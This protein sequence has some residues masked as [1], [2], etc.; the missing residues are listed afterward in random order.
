MLA[1]IS[2][3]TW[4]P[5]AHEEIVRFSLDLPKPESKSNDYA[6]PFLGWMVGAKA[7]V[8]RVEVNTQRGPHV[9]LAAGLARDDVGISFPDVPWAARSG[10][11][12]R[13]SAVKVPREFDLR[14]LAV[15]ENGASVHFAT[16]KG[17]RRALRPRSPDLLQPLPVT[18]IG[19]TGSSWLV[20]LLGRHPEILAYAPFEY[21]PRVA[22]YFAEVVGALVEP[23]SYLQT[24]SGDVYGSDWW[25]GRARQ[26]YHHAYD[27]ELERWI[28]T[29][30]VDDMLDFLADRVE[31]FYRKMA[32]RA[33]QPGAR[34]F[35]EK[36]HHGSFAQ[37]LLWELYPGTRELFLV[38]D[39]RDVASSIFEYNAKRGFESFGRQSVASDEEFVRGPL[40]EDAMQLL[41]TWR[42]RRDRALLVRYE[43]LVRDPRR[44]VMAICSYAGVNDSAPVVERMLAAPSGEHAESMADH[45][46]TPTAEES[47]GRW[48]HDLDPR[49]VRACEEALGEALAEFGYSD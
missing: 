20:W 21:E 1:R 35:A 28:G 14:L 22:S 11:E 18:T 40:R 42:E 3:V 16:V 9:P 8:A 44:T 15:F 17:T 29:R 27:P 10:F 49:L 2:D 33:E 12:G 30:H 41:R 19:R 4:Y 37:E 13:L 25:I 26:Y 47:I 7:P 32:E 48:R 46:T 24:I 36:V 43:D 45:R 31:L 38:R 39:F 6:V 23:A 34:M 5:E